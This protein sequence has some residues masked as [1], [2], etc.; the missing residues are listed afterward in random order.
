HEN[1]KN[2]E[3]LLQRGEIRLKGGRLSD[4]QN[5]LNEVLKVQ[6]DSA[7]A[8]YVLA[9]LRRAQ[10]SPASERQELD[11]VLTLKPA[12]LNARLDLARQQLLENKA[13]AALQTLDHAPE[14][15][16]SDIRLIEQRNWALLAL[17]NQAEAKAS[18]T[19]GLAS[20]R[21]RDLLLQNAE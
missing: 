14:R 20:S 4:A 11:E 12:L 5:D 2:V 1:P 8:H 13:A 10:K 9:R 15:Q 6:P 3:A 19:R 21:T 18:V 17:G 7:E 16:R